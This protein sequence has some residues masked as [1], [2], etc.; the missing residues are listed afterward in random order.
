MAA[1]IFLPF[2]HMCQMDLKD[3]E[4]LTLR[5]EGLK[6]SPW[7]LNGLPRQEAGRIV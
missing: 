3:H 7:F 2:C 1:H 6:L 4:A 5:S